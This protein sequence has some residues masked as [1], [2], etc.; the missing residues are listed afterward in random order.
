MLFQVT[1]VLIFSISFLLDGDKLASTALGAIPARWREG[2]T[3][4]VK[5][6]ETSFGSFV[7]G[8][9]LSALAYAL[10]NAAILLAFGLPYVA[11]GA[12][13]TGLL[14][15]VPLVGNYLAFIPPLVIC[16]VVRPDATL[17]LFVVL[18]V[19]QGIYMNVVSPRIMAKA[20]NMHPLMTMGSILVFGQL[21]G[22]W[23]ALFGI[24]IASTLSMLA[25]PTLQLVHNYLNPDPEP[26]PQVDVQPHMQPQ[27]S[28]LAIVQDKSA[29]GEGQP[30]GTS[31]SSPDGTC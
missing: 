25:R 11:V 31:L 23:G 15:I 29:N 20:V 4:V 16:L 28:A 14:I 27:P 2:A 1:L 22:F 9:L 18:V 10:L 24:P 7:R 30:L 19:V 12:L 26:D 3:L 17:V 8:Q 5:S 6:V 13:A 21:G